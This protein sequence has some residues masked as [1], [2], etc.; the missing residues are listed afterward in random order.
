[1]RGY[2][3]IAGAAMFWAISA[4]LGR[5][6]FTGRLMSG[7]QLPPIDPLILAQTRTTIAFLV[8]APMLLLRRGTAG[9]AMGRGQAAQALL[10]GVA[11]IAGS[12]YFYYYAI[13]KTSVAVAIVLQYT[14][15]IWVLMYMLVR[16]LQHATLQRLGSVALAVAGIPLAI[17]I[18]GYGPVTL[19]AMGV[20]A[21]Q[22]A[23]ISFAFY[24]VSG[25]WLVKQHD[26]WKVL[27]WA[28]MGCAVWWMLVNPPWR[29][30][31]AH[32]S[33]EQ[34][35]F[36]VVFSITSMLLPFSLYFAGLKH[37]DATRAIVTSCLEPVFSIVVAAIALGE[38]LRPLQVVGMALVLAATVLVQ[39][40]EKS[41][42]RVIG[43]SGDRG[44]G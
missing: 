37:L 9:M 6:V 41:G 30:V 42:N 39:I 40:P 35:I 7:A 18:V 38:D 15:P 44:I 4:T 13:Q 11:G 33:G 21:A 25:G 29:I 14:A 27:V 17:G 12:N 31:A 36:L 16:R 23:A 32:Y 26:A 34:W 20:I 22:L 5:A 28:L 24:N 1:V 2:L 3:F 43:P 8:L 10:L 19:S